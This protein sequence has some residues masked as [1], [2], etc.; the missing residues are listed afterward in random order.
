MA[1]GALNQLVA[2][3]HSGFNAGM[4]YG[5]QIGEKMANRKVGKAEMEL[6]KYLAYDPSQP[7]GAVDSEENGGQPTL[8]DLH[9]LR[10]EMREGARYA[11]DPDYEDKADMR[12]AMRLKTGY[13][14]YIDQARGFAQSGDHAAAGRALEHAAGMMPNGQQYKVTYNDEGKLVAKGYDEYT[15]QELDQ[16]VMDD[17]SILRLKIMYDDPYK[18]LEILEGEEQT[19]FARRQAMIESARAGRQEATD[20]AKT[21]SE[22]QLNLAKVGSEQQKAGMYSRSPRPY[23][24][25]GSG[26]NSTRMNSI[27]RTID[28]R[29]KL[30]M[31]DGDASVYAGPGL[32]NIQTLAGAIANNS[33]LSDFEVVDKAESLW[34]QYREHK[35]QGFDDSPTVTFVESMLGPEP[36][37]ALPEE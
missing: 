9:A 7:K 13:N 12:W 25:G 21:R 32:N 6:D 24:G 23:V 33:D 28:Q 22:T 35:R 34:N 29:Y 8:R 18:V 11:N 20:T 1:T 27:I 14:Q 5:E 15:G 17:K 36:T 3:L 16:K 4:G 10:T 2:G 31:N 26:S 37:G 19:A 30:S